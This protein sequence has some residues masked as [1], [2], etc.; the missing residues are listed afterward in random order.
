M[1]VAMQA[2]MLLVHQLKNNFLLSEEEEKI[3]YSRNV[4]PEAER[5]AIKALSCFDNKYY[6]ACIDPLNSVM[7]C[8]YLYWVSH[9]LYLQKELQIASKV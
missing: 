1:E 5:K 7:Y 2:T 9:L 6:N 3:I 4:L 8:N